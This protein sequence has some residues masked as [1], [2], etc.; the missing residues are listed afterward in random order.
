MAISVTCPK[1]HTRLKV[2]DQY[3][4]KRGP[5]PKCKSEIH[6]P[7]KEEEV[8]IA[9][10]ADFEGQKGVSGELVLKPIEREE[11]EFHPVVVVTSVAG[12]IAVLAV[13]L[14]IRMGTP[15]GQ[16]SPAILTMGAL[17]LAPGLVLAG[18]AFLRDSDLEPYSGLSLAIRVGIC[19]LVYAFT[20]AIYA[21]VVGFLFAPGHPELLQLGFIV[22]CL[23]AV[24]ILAA[25]SSLDL[26]PTNSFFHYSLYLGVTVILRLIMGMSAF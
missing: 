22:P 13:A 1:C 8:V 2:S 16:V 3:A 21:I 5:C 24:G 25:Y 11:T 14:V 19:S 20:W 6:V 23:A 18:Y 26:D 4:G 12:T 7:K 15:D 9:G 10:P 17:L